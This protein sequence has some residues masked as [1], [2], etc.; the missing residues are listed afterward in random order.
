MAFIDFLSEYDD[1]GQHSCHTYTSVDVFTNKGV[2]VCVC[3]SLASLTLLCSPLADVREL[4]LRDSHLYCAG[5][6]R[7]TQGVCVCVCVIE[8]Q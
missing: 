3:V 4:D 2:C 8:R 6:H 1:V 7:N 5:V